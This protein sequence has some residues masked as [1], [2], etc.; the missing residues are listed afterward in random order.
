[1]K[2]IQA[3]SA[4][5]LATGIAFS[6]VSCGSNETSSTTSSSSDSASSAS[7]TSSASASSSSGLP[8]TAEKTTFE[9]FSFMS[10]KAA[11]SVS[12][13][14]DVLAFQE[15][16]KRTNIDI[17]WNHPPTGQE[18]E[19]FN[20]MTASQDLPDMIYYDWRNQ[21]PGGPEKAIMD[22]VIIDLKDKVA[23]LA[24]NFSQMLE[25]YPELKKEI[26]TDSGALYMFPTI[27]QAYLE[28][29]DNKPVNYGFAY[30]KDWAERVGYDQDP[31][32]I[33]DWHEMLTLFKEQ[34]ANGNGDPNDEIPF[35]STNGD[36]KA[37]LIR[38][39]IPAWGMLRDFYVDPETKQINHPFN[40]PEAFLDFITTMNQWYSEGLIDP[41]YLANDGD[42][43]SAKMMSNISGGYC[44]T[45][46]GSFNTFMTQG[47]EVIDGFKLEPVPYP[48]GPAGQSYTSQSAYITRGMG[49]AITTACEQPD[50]A[51]RWMDYVM[52]DEGSMLVNFG[53]EGEHY[54]IQEDG[55]PAWSDKIVEEAESQ[56][57]TLDE[58]VGGIAI[59]AVEQWATLQRSTAPAPG[60]ELMNYAMEKWA[61]SSYALSLPP[62]TFTP[63]ES[64]QIAQLVTEIDT[65]YEEIVNK[66]IMGQ[67]PLSDFD[68]AVEAVKNMGLEEAL[69]IYNDAYTRYQNR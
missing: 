57:K 10:G 5:L 1:M 20:L 28:A 51:L 12:S 55:L 11:L 24:P 17:V 43:H 30:R 66:M 44:G 49:L 58:V 2:K 4:A 6:S 27:S 46:G 25:E 33:E 60:S 7:S 52:G 69:K 41:D 21:Y 67:A 50:I 64:A 63:E 19:Q 54:T 68:A 53:I 47:P 13:H 39:W 40:N 15:L 32:T 45:I 36:G 65:Y 34:D 23:E 42:S 14:E 31:L 38:T 16:E 37:L 35:V 62:M 26:T 48:I 29:G 59:G 8:I 56:H 61:P 3:I 18:A 22:Q 9:I